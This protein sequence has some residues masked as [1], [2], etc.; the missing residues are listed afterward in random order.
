MDPKD[1]GKL[2]FETKGC[3]ACHTVDGSAKIGPS[4][5]GTFGQ[6]AAM[7]DG[8]SVE[9]NADY[10]RTAIM[11]PQKQS[12]PGFPPSMPTYAGQLSE[13]EVNGVIAYIE[14]LK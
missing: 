6:Q 10:I 11:E 12:R 1:L 14:S 3:N 9:V 5:K 13:K 4:W 7:A 8:A 2:V